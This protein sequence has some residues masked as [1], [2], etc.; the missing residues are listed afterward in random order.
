MNAK[1]VLHSE[2]MFLDFICLWQWA[3]FGTILYGCRPH[4]SIVVVNEVAFGT[5][6]IL[7]HVW[8]VRAMGIDL[9]S[10]ARDVLKCLPAQAIYYCD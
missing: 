2:F 3:A 8:T 4:N 6:D 5:D 10:S 1:R 9:K 7:A